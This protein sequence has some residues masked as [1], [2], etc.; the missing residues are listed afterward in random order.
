MNTEALVR[1]L[2]KPQETDGQF[3]ATFNQAAVGIA[4]VALDGSW[5]LVND[6]VCEIVGYSRDELLALRFQD[7][8][9]PHDLDADLSLVKKIL[10]GEIETYSLD[11]RY[12]HKSGR[13]I[14]ITLTVSLV[15]QDGR[16]KYFI[17]IIKDIND[18]KRAEFEF[19]ESHHDLE[20][21]VQERTLELS[22]ANLALKLEILEREKVQV[23]RDSFFTLSLDLM[24]ICGFDGFLRRVNPAFI[25]LLGFSEEELLSR[26][27]AEFI[28][29]E[30]RPIT[31]ELRETLI[32][33][34]TLNGFENRYICKDGSIKRLSWTATALN[35]RELVYGIARDVTGIREKEKDVAEQKLKLATTSKM[36]ALGRMAASIAHEIN[37][38]LTVIY[39]QAHRLDQLIRDEGDRE[40]IISV[41]KSIQEMSQRISGIVRGLSFFSRDGAHD[42]M[43]VTQ[44]KSIVWKTVELCRSQLQVSKIE[45]D[46]S[47]V[48]AEPAIHCRP[49]QISQVL[50]NLINNA[51][52]AVCG[53]TNAK[54][55]IEVAKG[56]ATIRIDVLDNGPGIDPV[57]SS[58]LFEPFFTTK[59]IG[60]GVGLGLNIS[61]QIMQSHLGQLS[62]ERLEGWT[63]FS[64]E[65]PSARNS[66]V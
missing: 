55:K 21:L 38:P 15:R 59:P 28:H 17:S 52:D 54:I 40:K 25:S 53:R 19:E 9:H 39:G 60:K 66:A 26:P 45:L 10:D 23:E 7:I 22:R 31:E 46:I 29:P 58:S 36:N 3:R 37:N 33:G 11:K 12:I 13:E 2:S 30:D 63:K 4:H 49:V 42:P 43:E 64:I 32:N 5:L 8:T 62:Y 27:I 20:R 44:V 18:R 16:P 34:Q 14:W 6:K 51:H 41:A 47:D 56:D 57:I 35:E 48:Q 65:L 24:I 1:R 61:K 50:L